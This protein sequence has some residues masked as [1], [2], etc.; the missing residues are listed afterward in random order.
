MNEIKTS[1]NN[2]VEAMKLV[3]TNATQV[4]AVQDLNHGNWVVHYR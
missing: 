2:L 4:S 3:P 1:T